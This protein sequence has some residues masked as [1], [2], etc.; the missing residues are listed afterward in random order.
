MKRFDIEY[1]EISDTVISGFISL[2]GERVREF[3]LEINCN[4]LMSVGEKS[5]TNEEH[6][7]ISDTL[8]VIANKKFGRNYI[9]I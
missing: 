4:S 1:C 3:K 2:D 9:W 7:K 5:I 6:M 8:A